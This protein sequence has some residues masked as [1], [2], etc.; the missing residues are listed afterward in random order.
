MPSSTAAPTRSPTRWPTRGV[1]RGDRVV[2]FAANSVAA[3]VAFWAVLKANAVVSLVNPQSKPGQLAYC[4]RDLR[5][6]ALIAEAQLADEFVSAAAASPHLRAVIVSG[7][8]DPGRAHS[9]P[10]FMTLADALGAHRDPAAPAR[11]CLDVDLASI[12]YTSGST[13]EPKG[14]MLTHRNMLTAATSIAAYLGNVEDDVILGALPLAFDYGLYQMIM[15]FAAGARLVLEPSFAVVPKVVARMASER[16]TA[17]PL[18]PTVCSLLAEMKT[19]PEF[20]LGERPL[21][22]GLRRRP[23]GEAHRIS[24]AHVPAGADLFDVRAHRVQAV[25]LPSARRPRPEARERRDRDPQHRTVARRRKR[26]RGRVRTRSGQLVI[27]G[28]TVMQGYWDDPALTAER[29]K[30]GPLPGER[31][32]YTGDLCTRDDE[33]YLYF[34]ART[35]DMIKS[36]GEKVAPREVEIALTGIPGV[37]EAA[38]IGVPDPVLGQAVKAFVV[39]EDGITLL[40]GEILAACRRRLAPS[41][42]PRHVEF[43]SSLPRT[44]T[45]KIDKRGAVMTAAA[46]CRVNR[47]RR[48]GTCRDHAAPKT[49]RAAARPLGSCG[50][51]AP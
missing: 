22:D 47:P 14:V 30:P 31:V 36:R 25:H 3:V 26:P 46:S 5:A 45:G 8:L 6:S 28:A 9:L 40:P 48:R 12:I 39:V 43:L 37:K 1:K 24:R 34:V 2:V 10:G 18:L 35:D 50:A 38:V 11:R 17:L 29:L 41:G 21:R 32:L 51:R 13:G 42:V 23:D 27:R 4:L 19:L 7:A 20:D 44:A 15:A 49:R 16:V 33:G